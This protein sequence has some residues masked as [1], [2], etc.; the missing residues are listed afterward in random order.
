MFEMIPKE[1]DINVYRG[2]V[3]SWTMTYRQDGS[4]VDLSSATRIRLTASS[5]PNPTDTDAVHAFID[6]SATAN[7]GEIEWR[8]DGSINGVEGTYHYDIEIQIDGDTITI[9]RGKMNVIADISR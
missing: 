9:A 6:G 2:D 7:I 4:L 1:I 8:W 5:K 3:R